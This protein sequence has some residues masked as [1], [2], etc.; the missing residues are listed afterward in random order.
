MLK[1]IC[2]VLL[3]FTFMI[4][5]ALV[6]FAAKDGNVAMLKEEQPEEYSPE[7]VIEKY[8]SLFFDE[9]NETDNEY[10]KGIKI[11][12]ERTTVDD[13]QDYNFSAELSD[14]VQ[15]ENGNPIVVMIF[16]KVGNKY[17]LLS[18]PEECNMGLIEPISI[19]LPNTG[20]DN[21]NYI[22]VI[23]FPKN[24]YNELSLDNIQIYDTEIVIIK[25]D[26]KDTLKT[27]N[28]ILKPIYNI[29]PK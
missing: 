1:K 24:S 29:I 25:Y 7:A 17:K 3:I 26:V 8:S 4:A 13:I 2:F 23:A 9:N 16:V 20:K 19:Y 11:T 28:D 18:D 5:G 12:E 10:L 14:T 21:P 6:S 22:R 27:L 15:L